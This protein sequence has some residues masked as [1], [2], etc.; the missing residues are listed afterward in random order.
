MNDVR[1]EGRRRIL[2]FIPLPFSSDFPTDAMVAA[3]K[4]AAA[5]AA[6]GGISED[7]LKS[8]TPSFNI[9]DSFSNLPPLRSYSELSK[10][11]SLSTVKIPRMHKNSRMSV[12]EKR[13][14]QIVEAYKTLLKQPQSPASAATLSKLQSFLCTTTEADACFLAPSDA[15]SIVRI[16]NARGMVEHWEGAVALATSRRHWSEYY[17]IFKSTE[18]IFKRS[19]DSRKH[20]FSIEVADITSVQVMHPQETPLPKCSFFQIETFARIYYLMVHSDTQLNEWLQQFI[21][22]IGAKITRSPFDGKLASS[23]S[24]VLA[25]DRDDFYI[26]KLSACWK[27]DKKRIFNYRRVLFTAECIPEKFRNIS[28]AKVVANALKIGLAIAS[29]D[30]PTS[31]QW[32]SFMD[33]ISMF[34]TLNLSV[35]PERERAAL[36]LNLYHVMVVHGSLLIGPPPSWNS[37]NAFFSNIAYLISYEIISIDEL[38]HNIIRYDIM[39]L[40]KEVFIRVA[41]STY[42]LTSRAQMSRPSSLSIVAVPHMQFPGMALTHRDFRYQFCIN[43]GSRS[44]PRYVPIYEGERL[45]DQLDEVCMYVCAVS[46]NYIVG[47]L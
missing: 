7:M 17:M 9:R 1:K 31:I 30:N 6:D 40:P 26:A 3:D 28:P 45:D 42:S 37:W 35:I 4:V 19:V 34:Q 43:S 39:L 11:L 47:V 15:A 20:L 16:A 22:H 36:F 27:L 12:I 2:Y 24:A 14:R 10:I 44:M 8:L 38:E 33:H 5:A 23:S 13:R 21:M 25:N 41:D 18:L 29:S 32:V 46:M